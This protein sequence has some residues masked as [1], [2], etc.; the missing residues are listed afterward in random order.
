M[1]D[2]DPGNTSVA[3]ASF[4]ASY[5]RLYLYSFMGNILQNGEVRFWYFDTDSLSQ[6]NN[7]RQQYVAAAGLNTGAGVRNPNVSHFSVEGVT[8]DTNDTTQQVYCIV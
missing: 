8:Q 2:C 3:I 1:E 4:V 7:N 6:V 5:A